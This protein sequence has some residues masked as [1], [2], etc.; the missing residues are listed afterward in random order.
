MK[1]V[2]RCS[3]VLLVFAVFLGQVTQARGDSSSANADTGCSGETW[4]VTY[5]AEHHVRD[6]EHAPG[7]LSPDGFL[8]DDN[9]S[10]KV[11]GTYVF[12][13][14]KGNLHRVSGEVSWTGFCSSEVPECQLGP[15]CDAG[16]SIAL[17]PS[18]RGGLDDSLPSGSVDEMRWNCQPEDR[19]G[20]CFGYFPSCGGGHINPPQILNADK[21]R[22]GCCWSGD[23]AGELYSVSVERHGTEQLSIEADPSHV[24]P[25]QTVGNDTEA[26]S[27]LKIRLTCDGEPMKDHQIGLRIDPEPYS[28]WHDHVNNRPRGKLALGLNVSDCGI[29][30]KPPNN[31]DCKTVR[32]DDNGEVKVKFK[33]PLTGSIDNASYGSYKSGIA[34][35]YKITAKSRELTATGELAEIS[36]STTVIAR[37]ENLAP[38]EQNDDLVIVRGGT[39]AHQEGSYATKGVISAFE[40]LASD[41]A[42][43]Q[44]LHNIALKGCGKDEWSVEK[45]SVNDVALPDG[46]IFDWQKTWKP[47]HQTHNKGEGGDFNRFGASDPTRWQ[48]IGTECDGSTVPLVAWYLQVLLDLGQKYGRWDCSDLTAVS[49]GAVGKGKYSVS[50]SACANGELPPILSPIT[51]TFG[52]GFLSLGGPVPALY[53]PPDLHLHVFRSLGGD[54]PN[55]RSNEGAHTGAR[56]LVIASSAVALCIAFAAS[57]SAS[58]VRGP[59]LGVTMIRSGPDWRLVIMPKQT[60]TISV[61]VSNMRGDGAAHN[62]VLSVTLPMGLNFKQSQPAPA[63]SESTRNGEQLVWNLGTINAGAVPRIFEIDVAAADDVKAGNELSVGASL[64]ASDK[65]ADESGIRSGLM[66]VV[67]D[68][69]AMLAVAST[70]DGAPFT[71]DNPIDFTA[72]VTNYGTVPASACVL[73]MKIPPRVTFRWSD[74]SPSDNSN[75]VITWNLGNMAPLHTQTIKIKLVLDSILRAAAYGFDPNLGSLNFTFDASTATNQIDSSQGHLEIAR[76]PEPAG[77]NVKVVLNVAGAKHPGQLTV[78]KDVAYEVM[79]GNFGN[80]AAT[81]VTVRLNLPAGLTLAS[82]KP[83]A[84]RS[85]KDDKSGNTTLYWDLGG[86]DVG[87]SGVIKSQVH[88]TSVSPDGSLVTAKISATGRDVSSPEKTAH[89][90]RYAEK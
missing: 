18:G 28:G 64:S 4:K 41:F 89:S 55:K 47:S 37:V 59:Q 6:H 40:S 66:F 61:G 58:T 16:G 26:S 15:H 86:L 70:L 74:P 7:N 2:Y 84:T 56:S 43:Y 35:F 17:G 50:Q 71:V 10:L 80:A 51:I 87:Q 8:R 19:K 5:Q 38:I 42:N 81:G 9:S 78:G 11:S 49:L 72:D 85:S 53:V 33:V 63:K 32:T 24:V 25:N 22:D 90:L 57:W 75:N 29:D 68:P 31:K 54:G 46:G 39:A 20:N 83:P 76:Y 13:R 88:V 48:T 1:I 27:E 34:G 65:V 3:L 44:R 67:V 79:Y 14:R 52:S 77:S 23:V 36:A 45:L 82:T 30:T 69:T 62:T 12:E 73:K 21:L 60:A